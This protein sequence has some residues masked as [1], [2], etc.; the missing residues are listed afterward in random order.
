LSILLS[1]VTVK[2]DQ[3]VGEVL[4]QIH[5]RSGAAR[6]RNVFSRTGSGLKFRIQSI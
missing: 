3:F 5:F 2:F 6:I 4:F 1:K